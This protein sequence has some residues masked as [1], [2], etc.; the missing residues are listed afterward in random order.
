MKR[1]LILLALAG[2]TTAAACGDD[3]DSKTPPVKPAPDPGQTPPAPLDAGGPAARPAQVL[4]PGAACDPKS[5]T[6]CMGPG[7]KCETEIMVGMGMQSTA[8]PGGYCSA[9]CAASAE[10]GAGGGCPSA[11]ITAL[12]PPAFAGVAA[13]FLPSYCLDKCDAKASDCR[14]GYQCKS[15]S[16]LVPPELAA[17]AGPILAGIPALK[18]TYCLP[19]VSLPDAGVGRPPV[20]NP[21]RVTGLDGGVDSGI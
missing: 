12:L 4:N 1:L 14:T 15:L 13:G 19:P 11:E 10:C 21:V 3:R 18:T 20:A 16:E 8:L 6:D 2:V 17:G 9:Q 7:A 5:T